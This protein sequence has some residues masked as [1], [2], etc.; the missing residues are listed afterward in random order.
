MRAVIREVEF[1][2]EAPDGTRFWPRVIGDTDG[3]FWYGYVEFTPIRSGEPLVSPR[4]TTQS[5]RSDLDYWATGLER[6]FF[7]GALER[8]WRGVYAAHDAAPEADDAAFLRGLTAQ[9][10]MGDL[11]RALFVARRVLLGSPEDPDALWV[12]AI[13]HL[14]HGDHGAAKSCLGR[15]LAAAPA[16]DPRRSQAEELL[17]EAADAVTV[18][19]RDSRVRSLSR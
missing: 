3:R 15:F 8:A 19:P 7:E 9:E 13:A 17:A 18:A 2:I 6:I 12:V 10:E 5:K 16:G 14:S 4:E 11:Q 1:D